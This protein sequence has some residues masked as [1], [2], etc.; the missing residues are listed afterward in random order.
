MPRENRVITFNHQE[1]YTAIFSLC[2]QKKLP[3]P[4]AGTVSTIYE[5][6]EDTGLIVMDIKEPH[7]ETIKKAEYSYDLVAAALML[8]CRGLGI[9][10]P[11][12]AL[13]FVRIS[14]GE[15]SLNVKIGCDKDE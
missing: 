3:K 11:K 12:A 1:V 4:P 15:V 8:F 10:L 5:H 9:P 2:S 6:Q 7:V 14:N 13:K